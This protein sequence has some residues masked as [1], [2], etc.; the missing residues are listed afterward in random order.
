MAGGGRAVAYPLA[1]LFVFLCGYGLNMFYIT[2]LY[3]RGLA[4]GSVTLRS[5]VRALV[6]W[7]GNWL[8]GVDPKAWSCMHRMHH[9][10]SDTPLDPH[11]P[12]HQGLVGVALGQLHR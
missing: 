7:T 9:L 10:H 4:H 2:V 6:T 11:S 1:C 8:T 5:W 3:H 12:A